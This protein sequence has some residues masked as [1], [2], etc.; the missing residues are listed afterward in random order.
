MA[1]LQDSG[2]KTLLLLKNGHCPFPFSVCSPAPSPSVSLQPKVGRRGGIWKGIG[3]DRLWKPW[4]LE[5]TL[6]GSILLIYAVFHSPNCS[7][8]T[9]ISKIAVEI[10]NAVWSFSCLYWASAVFKGEL[11]TTNVLPRVGCA[12]VVCHHGVL[13]SPPAH[14][15]HFWKT[16]CTRV[17]CRS[18]VNWECQSWIWICNIG[19]GKYICVSQLCLVSV[20][21]SIS[22]FNQSVPLFSFSCHNQLLYHVYSFNRYRTPDLKRSIAQAEQFIALAP[23]LASIVSTFLQIIPILWDYI[24]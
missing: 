13:N 10:L 14:T 6:G 1:G 21:F 17:V 4:Q 12:R 5:Q 8:F 23:C 18:E 7:H 19:Y 16:V 2:L 20:L 9:L 11:L 3:A 22:L 15:A 24:V